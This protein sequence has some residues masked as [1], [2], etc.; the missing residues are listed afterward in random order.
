MTF[1]QF[2][3][4]E[5]FTASDARLL[6]AQGVISVANVTEQNAIPTPADGTVIYRRD[7]SVYLRR[8]GTTWRTLD[9]YVV[10]ANAAARDALPKHE[11]LTVFLRSTRVEERYVGGVWASARNGA[12]T[13]TRTGIADGTVPPAAVGPLVRQS[14][15]TADSFVTAGNSAFTLTEP[16]V[17]AVTWN[18]QMKT[19]AGANSPATGRTFVELVP[20]AGPST[21]LSIVPGED[22]ATLTSPNLIVG[23]TAVTVTLAVYLNTGN[24]TTLN[25][26]LNITKVNS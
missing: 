18:V 13:A 15:S 3:D 22:Q 25:S 16:G 14:S 12:F 1:K 4:G 8:S 7:L 2:E 23:A 9:D 5:I 21:R 6:M 24:P 11:G 10:V 19:A 26:I 20:S 17:Y